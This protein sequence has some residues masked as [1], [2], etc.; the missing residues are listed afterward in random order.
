RPRLATGIRALVEACRRHRVELAVLPS[1]DSGAARALCQRAQVE[2]LD[3]GGVTAIRDRQGKGKVVAVV[4][5][6]A[7]AAVTF[8]ACD[9]GMGLF[10]GHSG[11]FPA[12]ADLL[13][14]DL[15]AVADLLE[16]GARQ[17]QAVRDAVLFSVCA[18]ATGLALAFRGPVGLAGASLSV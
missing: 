16:T 11:L 8:A 15:T 18:N 13:A 4:S 2:L 6:G 10:R 9:L 17:R 3:A 14:P 1:G 7:H 5:D 12:R